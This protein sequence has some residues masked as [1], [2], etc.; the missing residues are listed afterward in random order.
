MRGD[1]ISVN[2]ELIRQSDQLSDIDT[3]LTSNFIYTRIHT[4]DY[5]GLFLNEAIEICEWSYRM[6]YGSGF[7]LN[8]ERV[9]ADIKTLLVDNRYPMGSATIMLYL[10]PDSVD[11]HTQ[12]ASN[13]SYMLSCREQLLYVGYT[14][15][16]SGLIANILPYDVPFAYHQTSASLTAHKYA[17]D[18][19]RRSG[20]H[21]ALR[22][23]SDN[24][25]V[26]ASEYPLFGVVGREIRTAPLS[27]GVSDSIERLITINAA[28][29]LGLDIVEYPSTKGE[30]L[31]YDEMFYVTPQGVSS[32]VE[33]E[34]NVYP[35]IIGRKIGDELEKISLNSTK[36]LTNSLF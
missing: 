14:N 12:I 15:W 23:S 10:F 18:Y 31:K 36:I 11:A 6:M 34:G 19:V 29:N 13:R 20:A 7:G 32:V 4:I 28:H 16:H 27:A 22:E 25:I 3:L 30:I 24:V 21:I 26:S 35:N 2:G 33:C 5:K 1:A 9:K 8:V 17:E